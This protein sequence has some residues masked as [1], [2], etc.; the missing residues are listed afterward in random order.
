M[1]E[2]EVEQEQNR[3]WTCGNFG[4]YHRSNI[5]GYTCFSR[6]WNWIWYAS[7]CE[8]TISY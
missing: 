7:L 3:T 5:L 1:H 2:Q 4:H 6:S 8:S